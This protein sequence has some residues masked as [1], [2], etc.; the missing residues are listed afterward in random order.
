MEHRLGWSQTHR[1]PPS[2]ASPGLG[3]K[4]C[5]T[6]PRQSEAVTHLDDFNVCASKL[7][8]RVVREV[9][10]IIYDKVGP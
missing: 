5:A 10:T 6:T 3:L 4:V 8:L 9:K 7:T 1:G 2:S